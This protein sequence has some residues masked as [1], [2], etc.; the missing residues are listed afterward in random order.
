MKQRLLVVSDSR[1]VYVGVSGL[2]LCFLVIFMSGAYR[3]PASCS[4]GTLVCGDLVGMTFPVDV[5]LVTTSYR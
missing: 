2:C 4:S 1:K 3:L 5:T